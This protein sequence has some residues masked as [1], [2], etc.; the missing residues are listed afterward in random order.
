MKVKYIE[1]ELNDYR[2]SRLFVMVAVSVPIVEKSIKRAVSFGL[3]LCDPEDEYDRKVGIEIAI[4]KAVRNSKLA[5]LFSNSEM[6]TDD[7]LQYLLLH[8]KDRF[9]KNPKTYLV[10]YNKY[11][12]IYEQSKKVKYYESSLPSELYPL[13]NLLNNT[14]PILVKEMLEII[15]LKRSLE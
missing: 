11:K 4:K 8:E 1:G 5:I 10:N 9:I 6:V 2:G 3:A 7:M 12:R 14:D 13:Y 15:C